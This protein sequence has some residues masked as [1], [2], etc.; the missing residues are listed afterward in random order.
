M[1]FPR[2]G[3]RQTEEHSDSFLTDHY[4]SDV[5]DELDQLTDDILRRQSQEVDLLPR[6][7]S[8]A[9]KGSSVTWML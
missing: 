8:K 6:L 2:D 7:I 1:V 9:R 3:E 5:F 4:L